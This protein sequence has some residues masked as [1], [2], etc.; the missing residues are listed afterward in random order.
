MGSGSAA[1][2]ALTR[3]KVQF[4]AGEY[5]IERE[6]NELGPFEGIAFSTF[7][8]LLAL[9]IAF[10]AVKCTRRQKP[11][12]LLLVPIL[13][14]TLCFGVLE[15]PTDQGFMV[16]VLAFS[17]AAIKKSGMVKG[18]MPILNSRQGLVGAYT[19]PRRHKD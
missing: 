7:R 11:L 4:I 1:I 8:F 5:E 17:L 10:S 9:F 19:R 2:T 6:M 18:P 3:G 14:V 15:Q 12:A 16:V 13:F